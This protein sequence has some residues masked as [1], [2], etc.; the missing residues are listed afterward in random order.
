[1]ERES[2]R[3]KTLKQVKGTTGR[4]KEYVRK[5][6]RRRPRSV[7]GRRRFRKFSRERELGGSR[8]ER[9]S[10]AEAPGAR[11]GLV[12]PEKRRD[13]GGTNGSF[14]EKKSGQEERVGILSRKKTKPGKNYGCRMPSCQRGERV[15][16]PSSQT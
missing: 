8:Q 3:K 15:E 13:E 2:A 1:V 6:R 12:K 16:A 11:W 9:I 4:R 5:K 10:L 14:K 7:P